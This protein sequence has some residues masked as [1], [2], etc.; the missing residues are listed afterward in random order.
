MPARSQF[1]LVYEASYLFTPGEPDVLAHHTWVDV[2][3]GEV[4]ERRKF[5]VPMTTGWRAAE[6]AVIMQHL[7]AAVGWLPTC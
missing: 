3:A 1:D 5:L 6:G 7:A 2:R 4:I